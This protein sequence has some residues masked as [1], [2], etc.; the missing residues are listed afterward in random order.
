MKIAA[1]GINDVKTEFGSFKT[2]T[3]FRQLT[4]KI[5]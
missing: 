4:E 1:A 3:V 2:E 5:L